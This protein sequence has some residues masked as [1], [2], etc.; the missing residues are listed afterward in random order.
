MVNKCKLAHYILIIR[1]NL[2]PKRNKF[3]YNKKR[4]A[5]ST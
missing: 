3:V 4:K 5:K 2:Y 1:T